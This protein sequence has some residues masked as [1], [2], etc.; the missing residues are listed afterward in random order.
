MTQRS[1]DWALQGCIAYWLA[2]H[3]A[4]K[5]AFTAWSSST[6]TDCMRLSATQAFGAKQ[7]ALVGHIWQRALL[8]MGLLCIPI[9]ILLLFAEPILLAT[10]QTRTVAAMTSSYIR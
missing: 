10:G 1:L 4:F 2:C 9:T 8:I 7:Y 3:F 5:P 6:T